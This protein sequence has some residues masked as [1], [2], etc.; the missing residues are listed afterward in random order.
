MLNITLSLTSYS[1]TSLWCVN[2]FNVLRIQLNF[3]TSA[4]AAILK[5]DLTI[6]LTKLVPSVISTILQKWSFA[7]Q[8]ILWL[9]KSWVSPVP[10]HTKTVRSRYKCQQCKKAMK[11]KMWQDK[12]TSKKEPPAQISSRYFCSI[13]MPHFSRSNQSGLIVCHKTCHQ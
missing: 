3:H 6:L 10:S 4:T 7:S 1:L 9:P 11:F 5:Q 12:K 2:N 8:Q 13:H